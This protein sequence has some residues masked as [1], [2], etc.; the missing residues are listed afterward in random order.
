MESPHFLDPFGSHLP[1]L[2]R[3]VLRVRAIEMILIL[4]YAEEL[5]RS[6]L[7]CI[8]T[9][10]RLRKA[11][12]IPDGTRKPVDKALDILVADRAI[13]SIEKK[14]IVEL[15]DYRNA[16]GHEIHTLFADLSSERVARNF[17]KYALSNQ[18]H[19]HYRSD[20]LARLKHFRARFNNLY[21]THHYA[22][23]INMN[24]L[25]FEMAERFFSDEIKRL[26]QHL[27]AKIKIRLA[28][29]H[30]LNRELSLKGSGLDGQWSPAGPYSKYDDG[31]L[32]KI[33]IEICYRLFEIGKSD[34]AVAHLM[35][36][37]LVAVRKRRN[38]WA[39]S[40]GRKRKRV[41]LKDLPRRKFYRGYD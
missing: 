5:K 7:D 18:K 4:F 1:A 24:P 16:V 27:P 19:R 10:D 14:E 26:E 41:D 29:I 40:G 6:V 23:T 34:L 33:G 30:N 13:S 12:R 15:I 31:R 11:Q 37:S 17:T 36:I 25:M 39:E 35:R 9:T 21:R 2:E 38:Q 20:A 3:T 28:N 32:T 22:R 8:R